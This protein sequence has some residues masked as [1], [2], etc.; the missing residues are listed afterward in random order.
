MDTIGG[1]VQTVP[2]HA[3][4][5]ILSF[6]S[7]SVTLT[8]T[9]G[10]GYS[11]FPGFHVCFYILFLCPLCKITLQNLRCFHHFRNQLFLS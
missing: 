5:I 1:F 6:P 11:I 7:P 4:V 2:A 10:R 9:A 8:I 3:T